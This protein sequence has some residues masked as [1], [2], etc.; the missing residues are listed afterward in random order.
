MTTIV[1]EV[2]EAINIV[3]R[4][5]GKV[6]QWKQLAS[7][8]VYIKLFLGLNSS[9]PFVSPTTRVFFDDLTSTVATHTLFICLYSRKKQ[10]RSSL[11]KC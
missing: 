7:L 10:L 4:N 2:Y 11:K 9:L 5:H 8:Q 3:L 1:I 6:V